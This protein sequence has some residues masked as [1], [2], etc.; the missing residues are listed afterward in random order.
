M[1]KF[2]LIIVFL[3]AGLMYAQNYDY[4]IKNI[5]ENTENADFGVT[6]Y[7]ESNLVFASSRKDKSI[8]KRVWEFN[9]QPFLELYIGDLNE[10]GEI[11]N[12]VSFSEN[13]NTK[14]H[15]SNAVFTKDLKTVYFS[16]DN[17]LNKKATKDEEGVILIQ[18]FKAHVDKDGEW[19]DIE[20]L[21]FNNNNYDT[22]H[23]ALNDKENK[24]YFV[25]NMPGSIGLTDIYVVDIHNDG[26]F[27]DPINLGP[28]VNTVKREMFPFI[29][30]NNV[31]Y[32]STDGYID[33]M[34]GLDIYATKILENQAVVNPKNLGIP[35]NSDKDDFG[36]VFQSNKESG[37]FSSNRSGGK[38]DDDIYYFKQ[39]NAVSFDCGQFL[40]GVVREKISGALL[41]GALVDLYTASGDRVE[42]IITDKYGSFSFKIDCEK[43]YKLVGSKVNFQKGSEVFNTSN[44][45]DTEVNVT[46]K[47]EA[48]EFV[49]IRGQ[50]MVNINPIYFDLD[51]SG[52]RP[53][54]AIELEKV[55]RLMLKYPNVK[56]DLGSHTD[57]RARD[58]YNLNLSERRAKASL[59]WIIDKGIDPSRITGKGYGESK[60]VNK[61][62]N[63]VRCSEIE[64]QLNRRTEFVILNPEVLNE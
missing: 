7:G 38:G 40:E 49:N 24:L 6:F 58:N 35:I 54:A 31:L 47:L 23:P 57:S 56:I 8:R 17:Y 20:V 3:S 22:G 15:E 13:I 30:Q 44:E 33:G 41:S 18:L 60:L 42:S 46:L 34:G 53:D 52:I 1:K 27:G 48:P 59:K 11:S 26:S 63:D 16:R 12:V 14:Y 21:P 4:S 50:L 61:C 19:V 37:Y 55:V 2:T 43:E 32:F 51:K 64:H 25:S 45:N 9:N 28:E 39:Q 5:N 36:M 62:A 29:D 10:D